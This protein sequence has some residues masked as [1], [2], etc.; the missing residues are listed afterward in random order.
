MEEAESTNVSITAMQSINNFEQV[1]P[2]F[3]FHTQ[4]HQREEV[5]Q[6]HNIDL[7]L[8]HGIPMVGNGE[9]VPTGTQSATASRGQNVASSRSGV[10]FCSLTYASQEHVC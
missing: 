10:G 3:L 8:A 9:T 2:T 5:L 7:H 1:F 4:S 6:L